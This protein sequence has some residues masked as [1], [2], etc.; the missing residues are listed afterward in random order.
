[1]F[2]S[3]PA[4]PHVWAP[5]SAQG[6]PGLERL[7]AGLVTLPVGSVSKL[8]CGYSP[9]RGGILAGGS[10]ATETRE[11]GFSNIKLNFEQK[12]LTFPFFKAKWLSD[13]PFERRRL[14]AYKLCDIK[15]TKHYWPWWRNTHAGRSP[16][17]RCAAAAAQ[18]VP[19]NLS[20]QRTCFLPHR[21]LHACGVL[22][23]GI[24]S[25]GSNTRV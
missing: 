4:S 16:R 13:P 10:V 15:Q 21:Q 9:H 18:Q 20:G 3:A 6:R 7:R 17:P 5:V 8:V 14:R 25:L 1:M 2:R 24:W 12:V 22:P 11:V 19:V 23:P